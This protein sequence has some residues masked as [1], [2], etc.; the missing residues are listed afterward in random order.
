MGVM[1]H[2]RGV[3][4]FHIHGAQ[5]LAPEPSSPSPLVI[6]GARSQ[7]SQPRSNSMNMP[8]DYGG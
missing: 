7:S 4:V 1:E 2:A 5:Q 3:P 8:V 6:G